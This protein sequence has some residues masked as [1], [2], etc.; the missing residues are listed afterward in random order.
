MNAPA[1]AVFDCNVFVQ[2][3]SNKRGASGRCLDAALAGQFLLFID[4]PLLRVTG[5]SMA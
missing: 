4:A 3:L 2:A 1:K 5:I